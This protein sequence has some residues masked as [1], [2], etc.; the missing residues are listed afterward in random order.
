MSS[1]DDD[2]ERDDNNKHLGLQITAPSP[3]GRCLDRLSEV[4]QAQPKPH[5]AR[6]PLD[7]LLGT[8]DQP[9]RDGARRRGL[10][11]WQARKINSVADDA[12]SSVGGRE[13]ERVGCWV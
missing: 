13:P 10:H 7:P 5:V 12:A 2:E 8:L 9:G 4:R 6:H 1:L 11:S 3:F